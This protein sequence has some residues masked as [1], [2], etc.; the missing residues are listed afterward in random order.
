MASIYVLR[1]LSDDPQVQNLAHLYKIGSTKQTVE[2][3][4]GGASKHTTFLNAPVE[5]VAEYSVPAGVEHK[6]ERLLHRLFS[7]VRLDVWFEQ[8]GV[9]VTEANEWFVVPLKAIDE[10]VSLIE[11]EAIKDYEYDAD[12]QAMK[13]RS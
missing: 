6:V 1:S 9:T 2:A 10:A 5:V 7:S 12:I 11:T 13:L 4:L 3:R 8:R